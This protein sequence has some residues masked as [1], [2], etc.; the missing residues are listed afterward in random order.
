MS[1]RFGLGEHHQVVEI[2]SND[3]YLLQ[4]FREPAC[5]CSESSRPRTSPRRREAIGIPTVCGSS[6]A[7][8]AEELVRGGARAD[9]LVGEQRARPR[10]RPQRLRRRASRCCSPRTESLTIEFPHLLRLIERDAVRHDLPRALLVLLAPRRRARVRRARPASCSTSSRCRRTAARCAST[11]PRDTDSGR[12]LTPRVAALRDE[13][14]GAGLH[15]LDG[16][17]RVRGAGAGARSSRCSNSSWRRNGRARRVAAYGA[18]AK[19]NTLLSYCGVGSDLIDFTVDRSPHKQGSYLP[20]THIPIRA[21]EVVRELRPDY[22]LILPWNLKEEIME[23]M[24]HVR[25]FGCRFVTP[26][27]EIR[28]HD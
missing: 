9:L 28:L 15:D 24:A 22:L 21:P 18:A 2:A 6:A 4:Y 25:T 16:L 1:G 14:A 27:P 10:A 5:R 8:T 7:Q 3:G 12:D 11:A 26:V 13:E 17:P 19:G 23:Q 20:G